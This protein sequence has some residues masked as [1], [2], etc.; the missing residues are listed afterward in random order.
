MNAWLFLAAY[1]CSGLAGLVYEVG[2]SRWLTLALGHSTA[3]SATVLAAFMGGL[4]IGAATAGRWAASVAPRHALYAYAALELGVVVAAVAVPFGLDA[5]SPVFARA[6]A[7]GGGG[8]MFSGVRLFS[9]LVLLGL[10]A[11]ALGATFPV[12]ARWFSADAPHP[13]RA[14]GHLYA[15]NTAGA[16]IGALGAGFILV[17]AWGVTGTILVGVGASLV[18]ILLVTIVAWR[19]GAALQAPSRA[20]PSDA[21]PPVGR[22]A[23]NPRKGAR[24]SNR[25]ASEATTIVGRPWLAAAVLGLSGFSTF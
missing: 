13:L 9:C 12:A 19:A 17:P 22:V 23:A 10:P 15:A 21:E 11:A 25:V 7:D 8:L 24:R 5:L 1:T 6:Y 14:A 2:W 4:A 20:K 3:A 16:A 18:A